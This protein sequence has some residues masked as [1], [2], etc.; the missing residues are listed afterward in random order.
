MSTIENVKTRMKAVEYLRMLKGEYTYAELTE[1][2]D[3][4]ASVLN[5]YIMGKVIPTEERAQVFTR[6][7]RKRYSVKEE[8]RKRIVRDG[9]GYFDNSSILYDVLLLRE[10]AEHA[11]ER[12]PETRKVLTSETDGIPVAYM[13]AQ[14][15]GVN[16]V[17]ARKKREVGVT[18]YIEETYVPSSSGTLMSLYLP[19]NAIQKNEKVLIVDDV[20]R[21][22]E[23]QRALIKLAE[24]SG[25]FIYGV[26]VVIC[27]GEAGAGFGERFYAL[28][29]L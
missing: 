4:P 11:V 25:A 27:I 14:R 12:F 29:K 18:N 16:A 26:F 19:T 22:G 10:I 21:T 9:E 8:I 3:L 6:E 17:Y 20:V 2:F 15:L 13:I 24:K 1:I 5:R 7:F 23:T 28:V